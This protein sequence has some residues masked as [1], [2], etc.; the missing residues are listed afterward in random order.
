[1][2]GDMEAVGRYVAEDVIVHEAG[3][4]TTIGLDYE[5]ETWRAAKS[6][7]PDLRHEVQEAVV[8][9][10]SVAARVV[11]TGTL[12]GI[13]AGL[14]AEGAEIQVDVAI[15]CHVRDGKIAEI[16]ELVD[17]SAYP[18]E[19]EEDYDYDEYED[20]EENGQGQ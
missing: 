18:E 8:Q 1:D 4:L 6:V 11:L 10:D 3:G 9:G 16:W 13:Y 12:T 7:M 17:T 14:E 15:F 2:A 19:D 5:R 20:E